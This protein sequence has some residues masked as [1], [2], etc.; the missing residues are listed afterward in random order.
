MDSVNS[1]E[2]R[3]VQAVDGTVAVRREP[4]DFVDILELIRNDKPPMS[5]L[6]LLLETTIVFD[7]LESS[8][9]GFK[10]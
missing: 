4:S 1:T 2:A 3:L 8:S 10:L 6:N 7:C 9:L 5:P